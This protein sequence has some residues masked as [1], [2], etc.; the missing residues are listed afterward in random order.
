MSVNVLLARMSV[1]HVHLVTAE[2][3][4]GHWIPGT[5]VNKGSYDL[6][7][8]CKSI[9]GPLYKSVLLTTDQSSQPLVV[10]FKTERHTLKTNN[11]SVSLF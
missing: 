4:R 1:Y 11:S 6:P 5:I 10:V 3:I 7:C 2:A 8:G 9:P